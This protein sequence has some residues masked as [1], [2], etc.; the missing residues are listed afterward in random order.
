MSEDFS[1]TPVRILVAGLGEAKGEFVR[2]YAPLTV[3]ALLRRLPLQGRVHPLM[4]GVSFILGMRRG[5]EKS[6]KEVE[7]RTIAYWP[8]N[9]S[10][11]LFHSNARTYSPVNRVGRITDNLELIRRITSGARI[12]IERA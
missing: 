6:T 8:M 1:K 12:T 7:A 10:V 3:E 4:G 2:I 11:C 5:E 9:D